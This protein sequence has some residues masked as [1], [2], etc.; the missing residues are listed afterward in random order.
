MP[1]VEAA[2]GD[3]ALARPGEELRVRQTQ[4]RKATTLARPAGASRGL[5]T[6]DH[7]AFLPAGC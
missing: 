2:L 6:G 5:T 7:A 3:D 1:K 4:L